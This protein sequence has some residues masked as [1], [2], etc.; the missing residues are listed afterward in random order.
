MRASLL[1]VKLE[2]KLLFDAFDQVKTF[3]WGNFLRWYASEQIEHSTVIIQPV[4]VVNIDR[5][6]VDVQLMVTYADRMFS[7]FSNIDEIQSEGA[8]ILSDF[9]AIMNKSPRW[10]AF[11][12]GATSGNIEFFE[13]KGGDLVAGC[14]MLVNVSISTIAD[15]CAVPVTDYDFSGD[16]TLVPSCA[17]GTVR[18]F[19]SIEELLSTVLVSSGGVTDYT[20]PD[21]TYTVQY[22]DGTLIESGTIPSGGSVTVNVPNVIT[23]LDANWTLTDSLGNTLDSGTIPSGGSATIVAP[24]ANISLN[25]V[26]FP[27]ILSGGSDNIQVRQSSGSTQVGSKQGQYWRI[28]DSVIT[29][30]N[31]AATT[32]STTNVLATDAATIVAPDG[33]VNNSDST[34]TASVA[35]GGALSLPDSQINVNSASQGNVVSVKT[36]DVNVTDGVDPVTPDAVTLVGN[37]LTIEVPSGAVAPV[38]AT[39]MKT[40]QTT[41]FRTGDDG[42]LQE[43]RDVD[44]FTLAENNPFGNTQRFTGV[45][46]GYYDQTLAGYYDKDGVATTKALAIPDNIV[47]D[48]STYNGTNVLGHSLDVDATSVTWGDAIDNALAYSV[49]SF[50]SGWRLPNFNE[51]ISICDFSRVRFVQNTV[52]DNLN[53]CNLW[54]STTRPSTTANAYLLALPSSAPFLDRAKTLTF[55]HNQ[56]RTFTV[57]GTTLT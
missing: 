56:V 6:K 4:R 47:I 40:G 23:C 29:L 22:V 31:T 45:T 50:I 25:G 27:S 21:A 36:I 14:A 57:T 51:C 33:D 2:S 7:D 48:W 8:D 54:T 53:V 49:G 42:D 35:S 32:L 17:N 43:G 9:I 18:V 20:A 44:F 26:S 3:Y 12:T 52:F 24:D 28:A 30:N 1:K 11:I 19:N 15:L 34:Y 13:Q 38:G 37:T 41:S 5:T 46:G 10:R 16:T 55:Q 39:L